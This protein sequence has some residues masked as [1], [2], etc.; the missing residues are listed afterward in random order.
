MFRPRLDALE[1]RTLLTAGVLATF[2]RDPSVHA[3]GFASDAEGNLWF[4]D[5][6]GSIDCLST[7][8]TLTKFPAPMNPDH[9]LDL[10]T[11]PESV[12]VGAD[13]NIWFIDVANDL[14]GRLTPSGTLT[15]FPVVE[16]SYC[17][18]AGPDGNLW[19]TGAM[20][21][22]GGGIGRITPTGEITVFSGPGIG[23]ALIAGPDGNLWGWAANGI[24][25]LTPN[26]VLTTFLVPQAAPATP[27]AM[28]VDFGDAGQLIAGTDGNLWFAQPVTHRIGR[29]TPSGTITE[30]SLGDLSPDSIAAGADGNIWF[31]ANNADAWDLAGYK[32]KNIIGR[33]SPDGTLGEFTSLPPAFQIVAGGDHNLWLYG[34]GIVHLDP[35]AVGAPD[36]VILLDSTTTPPQSPAAP[37]AALTQGA[38][39]IPPVSSVVQ[40]SK[41]SAAYTVY[42]IADGAVTVQKAYVDQ[43]ST[44]IIQENGTL[45]L[46]SVQLTPALFTGPNWSSGI[47]ITQI[48]PTEVNVNPDVSFLIQVYHDLLDRR[49]DAVGLG[50]WL[51]QLEKGA[52]RTKIVEQIESSSEYRT[53]MVEKLYVSMLGRAADPV[54]LQQSLASLNAGGT[55]AQIEAAILV[56]PEYFARRGAATTLGFL[57]ALYQDVLHRTLDPGGAM[58]WSQVLGGRFIGQGAFARAVVVN[59]V[60]Q[61]DEAS[62]AIVQGLYRTLLHRA[63]ETAGLQSFVA[64]LKQGGSNEQALDSI[65]GSDEYFQA[66]KL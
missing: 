6:G 13:G 47:L 4:G 17:I 51:D 16:Q 5:W 48:T 10:Y 54:G 8:G 35:R 38:P 59:A 46:A 9:S 11:S 25:R 56:S 33:L 34:A 50:H 18:S 23:G 28:S 29:M 32:P 52:T 42:P 53:D 57:T 1:E 61:S 45:N 15:T 12:A 36:T 62:Q 66:L 60:L 20:T 2:V 7:Q 30:F 49:P 65:M 24:G 3:L 22:N 19:F 40:S 58:T 27:A 63:A 37:S 26:G 31:T 55:I 44:N 64:A 14:V 21:A 39:E 41:N 43:A